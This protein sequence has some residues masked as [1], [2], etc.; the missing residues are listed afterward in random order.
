MQNWLL[1]KFLLKNFYRPLTFFFLR[2]NSIFYKNFIF[3]NSKIQGFNL[4]NNNVNIVDC[5]I[6]LG[7]YVGN[8]VNLF[9]VHVGKFCSLGS[10]IYIGFGQ[11]PINQIT[12]H[13]SF[14]S[15]KC[16]SGFTFVKEDK[17]EDFNYSNGFL[18]I[19]EDNVWV[20][21]NV[22]VLPGVRICEGAIVGAGSVVVKDV[23]PYSI[24]AGNPA[25][26]IKFRFSEQEIENILLRKMWSSNDIKYYQNNISEYY[27]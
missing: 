20:G 2:K 27:G 19:I 25:R 13:P 8:N 10:R 22:I 6:G 26:I 5:Q 1:I 9:S 7:S 24:I 16:Q 4:F 18:N 11:H 12:T 15:L 14:Y 17:S 3:K 21:S 23:P